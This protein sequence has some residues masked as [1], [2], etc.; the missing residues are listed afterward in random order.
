MGSRSTG[1]PIRR[2]VGL[3]NVQIYSHVGYLPEERQI[4][5]LVRVNVEVSYRLDKIT[6]APPID[7]R[8]IASLVQS[9]FASQATLLEEVAEQIGQEILQRWSFVEKVRVE[10]H[11]VHPPIGILA[12]TAYAGVE[13][14]RM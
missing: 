4:G 9:S 5:R 12:E 14:E 1:H 10:V 3:R 11:K 8:E 7:Y 2:T 6:S 13:M